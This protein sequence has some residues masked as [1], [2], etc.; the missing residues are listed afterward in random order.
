MIKE[1]RAEK[2]AAGH[3]SGSS[4]HH[5]LGT[6]NHTGVDVAAHALQVLRGDQRPDVHVRLRARP[7]PQRAD[8]WQ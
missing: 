7:K 4:I 6:L 2:I 1:R 3:V 8:P 5:Q